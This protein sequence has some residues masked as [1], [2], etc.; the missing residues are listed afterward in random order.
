[1]MG[2]PP[3]TDAEPIRRLVRPPGG[4]QNS[5]DLGMPTIALTPT[6]DRP[7]DAIC[8]CAP[9][10]KWLS[11]IPH[12]ISV[13]VGQPGSS[14]SRISASNVVPS[15]PRDQSRSRGGVTDLELPR[16]AL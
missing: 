4:P 11:A 15:D 3:T 1:M 2:I 7:T 16:F 5:R 8:A 14:L 13:T 6:T 12:L 9:A 10:V